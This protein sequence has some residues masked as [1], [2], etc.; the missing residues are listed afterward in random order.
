MHMIE[1][2]C[3]TSF[4]PGS[5][6]PPTA[7]SGPSTLTLGMNNDVLRAARRAVDAVCERT[8][9]S[10]YEYNL[11]GLRILACTTSFATAAIVIVQGRQQI[12]AKVK[13]PSFLHARSKRARHRRGCLE[14]PFFYRFLMLDKRTRLYLL[15][16]PSPVPL[17]C[18]WLHELP[19]YRRKC[20]TRSWHTIK[21]NF[22]VK[23]NS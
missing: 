2:V 14:C 11:P 16:P 17:P 3:N 12:S 8:W 10:L 18:K 15:D 9:Y 21:L 6:K 20:V 5:M 22:S 4:A 7:E 23:F 19:F 1:V 13:C